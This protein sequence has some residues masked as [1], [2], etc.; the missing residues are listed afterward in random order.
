VLL[1]CSRTVARRHRG[2]ANVLLMLAYSSTGTHGVANVLLMCSRTVAR[3]HRGERLAAIRPTLS[4]LL[5]VNKLLSVSCLFSK[6]GREGIGIG[7]LASCEGVRAREIDHETER[8]I[9]LGVRNQIQEF[10]V[11]VDILVQFEIWL[12]FASSS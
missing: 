5:I 7:G 4:H 2:V 10:G 6:V 9:R 1:M 12:P 11:F 3:R 8:N